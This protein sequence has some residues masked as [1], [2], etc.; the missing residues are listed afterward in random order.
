MS[1]AR[2]VR[3]IVFVASVTHGGSTLLDMLLSAHPAVC[4]VGEAARLLDPG[5][6]EELF[7]SGKRRLCSCGSEVTPRPQ[8]PLWAPLLDRLRSEAIAEPAPA[9]AA[10]LEQVSAADPDAEV[11]CDSSKSAARLRQLG[12]AL[13]RPELEGVE[14]RVVH[15]LRDVRSFATSRRLRFRESPVS[16]YR[17]F[18]EWYRTNLRLER[19]IER[20]GWPAFRLGYEELCLYPQVVLPRLCAFLDLEFVPSML[21]LS[22]SRGHVGIGNPM[23]MDATRSAAIQYDHRW[24]SDDAA[25]LVHLLRPRIRRYNR[26]RVYAHVSTP[27]RDRQ[28]RRPAV[29][30]V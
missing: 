10:L 6:R 20:G 22:R 1:P 18:G 21:D 12:L 4:G 23:R 2:R 9:Y 17:R 5:V 3:R 26:E 25:A 27:P 30:D 14:L 28:R 16:A 15:L 7:A 24:F 8:C 11:V 13:S 29:P 19:T